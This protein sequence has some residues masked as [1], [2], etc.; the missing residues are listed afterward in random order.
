MSLPP[1]FEY[2]CSQVHPA[3][4]SITRVIPIAEA[5]IHLYETAELARQAR[6]L[7]FVAARKR[8]VHDSLSCA[9]LLVGLSQVGRRSTFRTPCQ[10]V[11]EVLLPN[12]LRRKGNE[13][14]SIS[15]YYSTVGRKFGDPAAL[16]VKLTA[17]L[18]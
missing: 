7:F 1:R 3:S 14:S 10:R 13:R 5:N 16:V 8:V 2:V 15:P 11:K 6:T 17:F 18:I 4:V 12:L 9:F